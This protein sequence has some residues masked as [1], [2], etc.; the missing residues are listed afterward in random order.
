V[1]TVTLAARGYLVATLVVVAYQ[2]A[3][4]LGAPWGAYAMGGRVPGRFPPALRVLTLVQA[5]VLGLLALVVLGSITRSSADWRRHA[6]GAR[7]TR[8]LCW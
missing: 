1:D 6:G 7:A 8:P 4:A 3:L 5:V 2:L